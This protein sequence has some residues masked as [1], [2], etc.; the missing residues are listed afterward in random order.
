[1]TGEKSVLVWHEKM[2]NAAVDGEQEQDSSDE[3]TSGLV[4]DARSRPGIME[5]IAVPSSKLFFLI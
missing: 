1:M 5:G 4:V 3:E 2:P